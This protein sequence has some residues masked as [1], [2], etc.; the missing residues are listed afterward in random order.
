[1]SSSSGSLSLPRR[2]GRK[3]TSFFLWSLLFLTLFSQIYRFQTPAS[4]KHQEQKMSL[5]AEVVKHLVFGQNLVVAD[6]S[7]LRLVQDIDFREATEVHDGWA[8]HLLDLITTLDP[9]FY[10][11]Y[12]AGATS[13]SVVVK[14]K[15]G[16]RKIF[17]RGVANFP[18]DWSLA[19]RSAY[20]Y[21]YEMEDCTKAAA[22]LKDA[23]ANGAPSWVANLSGRL[24]THTGQI[25]L[26]RS[27]LID[28]IARFKGTDV[29]EGF[30]SRLKDLESSAQNYEKTGN[31]LIFNKCH[32]ADK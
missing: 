23:V 4:L 18:S 11:A 20:H 6:L 31:T 28:A 3:I 32:I 19:Y 2:S 7:W 5:N 21:L 22:L 16:A 12:S 27:V 26:A 13:L 1:V 15:D 24:F 25:D 30:R 29:E 8:Y 17:D 14:D 9:R 10:I